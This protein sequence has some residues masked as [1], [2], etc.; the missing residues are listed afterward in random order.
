MV[1]MAR[2][3]KNRKYLRPKAAIE[4]AAKQHRTTA[5]DLLLQLFRDRRP[6]GTATVTEPIVVNNTLDDNTYKTPM[7]PLATTIHNADHLTLKLTAPVL[8]SIVAGSLN[9][10]SSSGDIPDDE[11]DDIALFLHHNGSFDNDIITK[12]SSSIQE[13]QQKHTASQTEQNHNNRR[14]KT[15]LKNKDEIITTTAI[16]SV[17]EITP[18]NNA[19]SI[20]KNNKD[21]AK[22]A[23]RKAHSHQKKERKATKTL[24]IVLSKLFFQNFLEIKTYKFQI[25]TYHVSMCTR[26]HTV[27]LVMEG[28]C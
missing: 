16:T 12:P 14:L 22:A 17:L 9:I 18:T 2:A 26:D 7:P 6:K 21:I 23:K 19:S 28:S 25:L 13:Q 3:Q 27:F 8:P 11:R 10:T 4:L 5:N 24:V 1:I 20:V 15:R